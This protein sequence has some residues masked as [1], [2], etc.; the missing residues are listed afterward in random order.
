MHC[1]NCAAQIDEKAIACTGCGLP[2]K[3]KRN[4]CYNCGAKTNPEQIVCTSCGVSLGKSKANSVG[5]N[6]KTKTAAGLWAIFLGGLGIHKF[7]LGSWGWGI[8][9]LLF[10]WTYVPSL[11]GLIEGIM[12][13]TMDDSKFDEKYNSGEDG[14]FRF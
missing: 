2:P 5:G 8:V 12:Y 9:Y 7:Y 4:F 6:Y 3:L 1:S 11:M 14:A 13:L 10:C